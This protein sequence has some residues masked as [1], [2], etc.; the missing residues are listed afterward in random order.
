[1]VDPNQFLRL[2]LGKVSYL[3]SSIAGFTIEQRESL[4]TNKSAGNAVAWR[5]VRGKR[6]PAFCL[7]SDLRVVHHQNWHRAVFLEAIPHAVGIA[8]DEVQL[9]SRTETVISPFTPIGLAPT[10]QGHLFSGAW[11]TGNRVVLVF[12]P[13]AFVA[14]LQSLEDAA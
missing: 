6:W 8:V 1:M 13:K 7:D 9:L 12:E 14:Y 3:L 2:Q 11:V 10:R 5:D 4:I